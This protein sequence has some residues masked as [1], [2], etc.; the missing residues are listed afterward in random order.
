M[1]ITLLQQDLL[2]PA[3]SFWLLYALSQEKIDDMWQVIALALT[4]WIT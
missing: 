3:E 2:V 1:F 4:D